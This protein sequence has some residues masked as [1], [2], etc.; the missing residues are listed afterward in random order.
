MRRPRNRWGERLA[1]LLIT[2]VSWGAISLLGGVVGFIAYKGISVISWSFLIE[3]MR[4]GMQKGGIAPAIVGSLWVTLVAISVGG[5]IGTA[6]GAYLS[7]FASHRRFRQL[8]EF[9]VTTLA[10]IPS[11]VYGLFGLA[12]FVVALGFGASIL[13]GGLTLAL[14]SLPLLIRNAQEAF[15]AV[16]SSLKEASLGL[17]ASE[18]QTFL[19]ITLPV[20]LPRVVTGLVLATGRVLG[21]TAPILFTVA[22]YY[23]PTYPQSI[24]EPTM[25]LPYHLYALITSGI[26]VK[27]TYPMAFGTALTLLLLSLFFTLIAAYFRFR[28]KQKYRV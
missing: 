4:E 12:L 21:E 13:A 17:G 23:L 9:L 6:A 26:N 1:T 27:E 15:S 3:P 5:F 24:F 16:P 2:L 20:A 10:G 22:A 7:E 18:M 8:I 28:L 14:L 19:R 11:V 25:L